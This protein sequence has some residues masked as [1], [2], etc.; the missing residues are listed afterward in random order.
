[1]LRGAFVST[2]PTYSQAHLAQ[3]YLVVF[4]LIFVIFDFIMYGTLQGINLLL[5]L[6]KEA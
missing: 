5:A 3:S 6:H 2:L 4:N 1:M